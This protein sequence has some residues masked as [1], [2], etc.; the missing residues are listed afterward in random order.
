MLRISSHTSAASSFKPARVNHERNAAKSIR[1]PA[2]INLS[3]SAGLVQ[4][5]IKARACRKAWRRHGAFGSASRHNVAIKI[6]GVV[7]KPGAVRKIQRP[8]R[9]VAER[10]I[11]ETMDSDRGFSAP[12][13]SSNEYRAR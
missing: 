7:D 4:A 3:R 2:L 5:R 8:E 12:S 11:R 10:R 6:A 9:R 1:C 13:A